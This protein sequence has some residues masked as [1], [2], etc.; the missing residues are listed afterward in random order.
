MP[1]KKEYSNSQINQGSMRAAHLHLSYT[2]ARQAFISL[3]R[4]GL[5]KASKNQN[6]HKR[7][8]NLL[9]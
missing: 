3:W 8:A 5:D 6:I 7:L 1:L 4:G 9:L 2:F